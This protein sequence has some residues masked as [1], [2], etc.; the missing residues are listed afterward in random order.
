MESRRTRRNL[1]GI[2][3]VFKFFK[4]HISTPLV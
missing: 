3:Q 4:R 2:K 1:D